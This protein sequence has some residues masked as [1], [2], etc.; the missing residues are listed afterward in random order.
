MTVTTDQ[1]HR[2]RPAG[3]SGSRKLL[4]TVLKVRELAIGAVLVVM[5]LATQLDNSD[6]LSQQ[7]IK[8]LLLNATILVL[9]AVGQAMV[10]IT[11]NVDLSVGSTLGISAFAAGDYLSGGGNPLVAVVLAVLLG[12]AL[13]AVNGLLVS[14]GRVPALVVTLGTLYIIRG[15]D[16]VWVGSRQITASQL[17]SGFAGFGHDGLSVIPYLALLTAAVLVCVAYYLRAYR[18]GRDL[19]ALGSNPEAARLA[20]V[21][22][23][24]RILTAYVVCG[25]LAGLAGALYLARFGNVDSGTGTGY[26]LTVVSA[27]VV[28]GVAFTGGSGTV[29][30][31]AL[32][33]LLLTS[34]NSVLPSI[35]VSSVWVQAIDGFLLLLAIAVDR[36]VA[37]RV[38]D[39]LRKRAAETRSARHA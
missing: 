38:A 29:Y 11:R 21:P 3:G 15:L 32:G 17:P 37:L 35:G 9:V 24:R 34:I 26:E 39:L 4:D 18:G 14:L 30:G 23:R 28:G 12:A 8:D 27:V 36:V 6:F 20:G 19:Y 16:S 22:V 1:E 31:A 25:A 7:G 33:A 2:A 10:V 5:L 13:G